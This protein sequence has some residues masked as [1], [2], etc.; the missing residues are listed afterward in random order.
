MTQTTDYR[1]MWDEIARREGFEAL[2]PA[3]RS[4][5][6]RRK[7][8]R[9]SLRTILVRPTQLLKMHRKPQQSVF[10]RTLLSLD[11]KKHDVLLGVFGP[12]LIEQ[13]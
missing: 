3:R 6:N 10:R 7:H 8:T 11:L 1:P 5:E 12:I 13:I 4:S 9:R 2:H